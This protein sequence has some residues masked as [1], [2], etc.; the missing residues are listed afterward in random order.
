[1]GAHRIEGGAGVVG[2]DRVDDALVLVERL[3]HAR[4]DGAGLT[5]AEGR[6]PRPEVHRHRGDGGVVGAP[7]DVVVE[8]AVGG[9]VALEIL[10][11]DGIATAAVQ[12]VELLALDRRQPLGGEAGARR[13]EL[14]LRL[15]HVGELRHADARDDAATPRIDLDEAAR[16]ELAQRLTDRRARDAELVG[17]RFLFELLAGGDV[18]LGDTIG[19]RLE[20]LGGDGGHGGS[21]QRVTAPD[22]TISGANHGQSRI[23]VYRINVSRA[24]SGRLAPPAQVLC[25]RWRFCARG[26]RPNGAAA[27]RTGATVAPTALHQ[28]WA[29]AEPRT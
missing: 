29:V 19:E 26:V 24:I 6:Q 7:A 8:V 17:E 23:S 20:Y 13:L 18:P 14:A 28:P 3:L 1:M 15:Q 22:L 5:L 2:A 25:T 16:A 12:V 10:V 11:L 21:F 4:L 9:E 27:S